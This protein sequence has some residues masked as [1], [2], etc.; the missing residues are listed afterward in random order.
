MIRKIG[1]VRPLR[2]LAIVGTC[3]ILLAGMA[4]AYAAAL[5]I[6]PVHIEVAPEKQFCALS[7]ANDG[8]SPATV[9]IR[10]FGWTKDVDGRDQL[11]PDTGP[12]I[13]PAIVKIP[14]G[15]IRLI[16]C[17]LPAKK[18][19]A[20]EESYRLIIDELPTAAVAAGTVRTLLR[21]SIPLFRA[22]AKAV[23]AIRWSRVTGADGQSKLVLS[24]LGDRH[25]EILAVRLLRAPD[26]AKPARLAQGFYLL[27]GGRIELPIGAIGDGGIAG[28]ELETADGTRR[29]FP[30]DSD[31]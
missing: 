5:R 3:A 28:V 12:S 19:G 14:G 11:D 29:A 23:A 10:G 27:A 26:G 30:V 20:R 16:R 4:P 24:N 31:R 22:P 21:I 6:M 2:G 1:D 8:G 17:S 15:E 9:Q 18:V 25:A 7:I 13:N